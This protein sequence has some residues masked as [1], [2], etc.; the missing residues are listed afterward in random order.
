MRVTAQV[1]VRSGAVGCSP[2][3]WS[4]PAWLLSD[5]ETSRSPSNPPR[6]KRARRAAH[7]DARRRR[8]VTTSGRGGSRRVAGDG[9]ARKLEARATRTRD[10]RW[11]CG[12][13]SDRS[14]PE[15]LRSALR[16]GRS[17]S[18]RTVQATRAPLSTGAEARGL[19]EV[20]FQSRLEGTVKDLAASLKAARAE[21]RCGDRG[22]LRRECSDRAGPRPKPRKVLGL[23]S[24]QAGPPRTL[25]GALRRRTRLAWRARGQARR[26][27]VR[28]PSRPAA[29]TLGR[30]RAAHVPRCASRCARVA[31]RP[32]EVL[33]T[34]SSLRSSSRL[35][36]ERPATTPASST[37]TGPRRGSPVARRG[38]REGRD[39]DSGRRPSRSERPR[40]RRPRELADNT[41]SV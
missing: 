21:R 8:P 6:R 13:T 33:S 17:R 30:T 24:P 10:E 20:S 18:P 26:H 40:A 25:G 16:T 4:P 9:G 12:E 38:A 22:D 34:R 19:V 31:G 1:R 5:G 23:R 28:A 35:S 3:P 7:M 39:V 14:R 29:S 15:R 36:R 32:R 41:S 2:G 27:P 11:P 37:R